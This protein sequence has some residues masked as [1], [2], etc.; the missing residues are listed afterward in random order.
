VSSLQ[1][2]QPVAAVPHCALPFFE[3]LA[4]SGRSLERAAREASY[5]ADA[6]LFVEGQPLPGVMVIV[7][8]RVKLSTASADGRTIVV[9]IAGA[10]EVL[11]LSASVVGRT[12]ELTA[13]TT[14][15]TRVKV[16]PRESFRQWL[17]AHPELAFQIA[18][19]LAEEYNNTCHQLRSML[20]SHTATERLA[21]TLLQMVRNA[22]P[23]REL[24]VEFCLTHQE[25]AEM[26]GT[27]R[28]TVTRLLANLRHRGL[29][30]IEASTLIVRNREAL[31]EL[32]HGDGAGFGF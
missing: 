7:S 2:L 19:E 15:P 5:P 23:D 28:E 17:R 4:E 14:E 18:Q 16:I 20:L 12:C 30:E 6:L 21:R 31:C 3:G 27:S 24:R 32:A 13:E 8:G 22:A 29:I 11:G 26:I 9:R 25:L 1:V 10:G